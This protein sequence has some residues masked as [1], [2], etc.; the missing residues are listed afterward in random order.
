MLCSRKF[1]PVP[2]EFQSPVKALVPSVAAYIALSNGLRKPN[3]S[4]YTVI[5]CL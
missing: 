5:D 4:R 1:V 3:R 2:G